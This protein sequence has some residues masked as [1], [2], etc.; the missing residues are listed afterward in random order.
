[1]TPNSTESS[2]SHNNT[3]SQTSDIVTRDLEVSEKVAN[4]LGWKEHKTHLSKIGEIEFCEI[5]WDDGLLFGRTANEEVHLILSKKTW[6]PIL[7]DEKLLWASCRQPNSNTITLQKGK[8]VAF[9]VKNIWLVAEYF[10]W[11]NYILID[12]DTYKE[13]KITPMELVE[14]SDIWRKVQQMKEENS[15]EKE[16]QQVNVKIERKKQ[17]LKKLKQEYESYLKTL[18]LRELEE[19]NDNE[20]SIWK[21][22]EDEYTRD[23]EEKLHF[24]MSVTP[25]IYT[26]KLS[27]GEVIIVEVLE[28]NSSC[29]IDSSITLH[30]WK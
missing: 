22:Q 4:L 21:M 1:M 17:E 12:V 2:N 9:V 26:Y 30:L 11:D 15:V 13:I 16:I 24:L 14:N 10:D 6:V 20:Y 5:Y 23:L 25:D 18:T 3:P 19:E 7:R 29:D 28:E 27:N 8:R